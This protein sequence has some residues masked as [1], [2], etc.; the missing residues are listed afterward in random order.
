MVVL[1]ELLHP[2]DA[3]RHALFAFGGQRGN[4]AV[5][6]VDDDGA[7]RDAVDA[8]DFVARV[9]PETVVAANR[10]TGGFGNLLDECFFARRRL[11]D[12]AALRGGW[13]VGVAGTVAELLHELG[14]IFERGGLL[15]GQRG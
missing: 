1:A 3:F 10:A 8:D 2:R 5:G 15:I 9:E 6:W 14:P 13:G 12:V 4:A 7:E 11:G